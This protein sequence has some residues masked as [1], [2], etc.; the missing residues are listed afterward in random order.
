MEQALAALWSELLGIE[1]VGRQDDFFSLGGHSLLAVTLV[2][3]MRRLDMPLDVRALFTTP[4]LA[5]L[6]AVVGDG[7][8]VAVPANRIPPDCTRLTPDLLPLVTLEQRAIDR[9]VATVPGGAANVQDIYPLGPLQEGLLF[10]HLL[11]REGDTYVLAALFSFDTRERLEG[12]LRAFEAVIARHDIFRT[13]FAWEGLSEPVQ[14]VWRNAPLPIE[15]VTFRP[16]VVDVSAALLER[17]DPRRQQLDLRRAPLFHATIAEDPGQGRWLLLLREHHLVSDHTTLE[18]LFEEIAA[19]QAGRFDTLPPPLPYRNYIAQARLGLTSEAHTAFFQELLGEVDEPTA[20]FGHLE[21]RG[22]GTGIEE[23]R[24]RLD[25]ALAARLR[26]QARRLGV[27][28]AS[29]FHLAFA[30]VLAATSGRSEVVFGTVL[31]GRL[32]GG[33]GADRVPGLFINTLPVRIDAGEEAVEAAVRRTHRTLAG[34]LRHEHAPLALAQRC[35]GVVA[36]TPLFSALFNYRHSPERNDEDVVVIGEGITLVHAEERTNYPLAV[37]VDDLGEGFALTAQSLPEI[38]AERLCGYLQT[39]TESLV[40]ALESAPATATRELAVLPQVERQQVLEDWNATEADY[41]QD[42]CIHQL[43][44][45]QTER[46]PDAVALVFEE[47]SLSYAE[48]NASANRLAHHLITQGIRPDDRVAIGVERS[49]EMVV[50][51]LAILKAGG[52]Y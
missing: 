5:E 12:F 49:L 20:P 45:E 33:E 8:E 1:R 34:L 37:S 2:G 18:V 30:R 21:V 19:H 9:I 6:A 24:R 47:K 35:S 4:T 50:G 15:E 3:R 27:T 44:E 32:M 40:A 22:D 7:V 28:P 17:F 41:P 14:V 48:L 25:P 51:L 46:T 16:D 43:F 52:A 29:L 36:P 13:S 38:G 26:H 11:Q 10:H 23:S 39:A 31:F 42:R